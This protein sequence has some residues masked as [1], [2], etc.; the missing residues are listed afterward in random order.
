MRYHKMRERE[1]ESASRKLFTQQVAQNVGCG[2]QIGMTFGG[3][4]N[5][6]IVKD[7]FF[8]TSLLQGMMT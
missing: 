1:R 8:K 6:P 4:R 7:N 3:A 2:V 5:S